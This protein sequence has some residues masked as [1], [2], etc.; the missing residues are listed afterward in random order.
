MWH[1]NTDRGLF[2][3]GDSLIH[4]LDPRL[5]V[6]ASLFLVG[7]TFASTSWLSLLL[8]ALA[9][10]TAVHLAVLPGSP[11]LLTCWQ[12][13]WLLV[14]SL[15][16]HLLMT[17][18]RTL[19]GTD[20]LSLDGLLLGLRVN[21]QIVLALLSAR[22]LTLTTSTLD[23]TRTFGWF[24]H[25]LCYFGFRPEEWQR[26]LLYAVHLLPVVSVE[27][28]AVG[29]AEQKDRAIGRWDDWSARL[30]SLVLRLVERGDTLAQRVAAGEPV[31][32]ELSELPA[33]LPL[34]VHEM[35]FILTFSL[36]VLLCRW[37]G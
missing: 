13:R 19:W 14:F 34:A 2:H 3:P 29:A 26:L 25:P 23:L 33:L 18:G 35:L 1:D 36:L 20:W 21:L 32:D 15:L 7:L 17:P 22:L 12:L 24:T 9:V 28:R 8:I 5:K 16:M 4:Q 6:A 30:G 31:G 10:A 27:A 37:A 11:L